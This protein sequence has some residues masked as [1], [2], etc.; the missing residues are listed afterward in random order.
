MPVERQVTLHGRAFVI[1]QHDDGTFELPEELARLRGQGTA[2]KPSF[3]PVLVFR[4]PLSEK[5]VAANV[6]EHGAGGLN[7]DGCR[8]AADMSEFFSGTGNPRSGMG[9][10]HG[11]GMGDG[12]GGENANPP[13][14]AGR[15]PPNLVLCHSP[16]CVQVGTKQVQGDKRGGQ[17]TQNPQDSFFQQDGR[18]MPKGWSGGTTGDPSGVN[19]DGTETVEAWECAEG[20]PVRLLDEQSGT[21]KSGKVVN[22]TSL[23]VKGFFGQ[24]TP[25]YSKKANYGVS[26][27]A[28]RFFPQ[29]PGQEPPE[30]PF[31]YTGKATKS[32]T[33][34]DGQVENN[35]PCLHPDSLVMTPEGYRPISTVCVDSYVLSADGHFHTVEAVTQHPY[36]SEALVEIRVL[37]S[38]ITSLVTDN[39]PYLIWRPTRHGN[40]I[41][42]GEVQWLRAD[43]MV[44][45]DYTMTPIV[46]DGVPGVI[47]PRAEDTEFWFLVGLY[48]AEGWTQKAGHGD[49]GYPRFALHKNE[50]DLIDRL[51]MYCANTRVSVYPNGENGVSVVSFDP[52]LGALFAELCGSG[53]AT[54]QLHPC[55]WNL[56]ESSLSAL[57]EG[58]MAG[59]GGQVR[60]YLQAKTSSPLLGSQMRFLGEMLGYKVELQ[61]CAPEPGGI[62]E[63]A[64][65]M[66]LPYY[67]IRMCSLNRG[68]RTRKPSKPTVLE[69]DGNTYTLAYVK[70]L[71]RVPYAGDVVNISVEGSHTFQTAAG[72]S[73]NTKKPVSLMRW[74][75]KLVCPPKGICLDPFCGSGSTCVAAVE[76]G[77]RFIG[78]EREP[79][80]HAIA[81]KRVGIVHEKRKEADDLTSFVDAINDLP[82]E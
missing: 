63:R 70:S 73:H 79:E 2:L 15:W 59:D 77:M 43:E 72:M 56:P 64:F 53:A 58:Y 27:G 78:I 16:N 40:A 36:T 8:V 74:L 11:Y 81:E 42:G 50:T 37:G 21:L 1:L 51:R 32:E 26:G 9:H 45:G 52:D 68:P 4:K 10:A 25:Y 54:K 69:H 30:A 48:L 66:V 46:L 35:H 18:S 17:R 3:E 29:F 7:I 71:N 55:V 76:Q 47:P 34:L 22:P 12:Y 65:K 62:G 38:N 67:A 5:T 44:V 61:W 41:T 49:N 60:T 14:S 24:T 28:S 23:P 39:H 75:V 31:F 20:C 82:E 19:A 57:V 33:T 6:L 80:Y 13:H